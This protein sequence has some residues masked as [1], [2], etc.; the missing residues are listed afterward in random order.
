MID[1][2]FVIR[3]SS[4]SL[5]VLYLFLKNEKVD[6]GET[7]KRGVVRRGFRKSVW[8][9]DVTGLTP[10]EGYLKKLSRLGRGRNDFFAPTTRT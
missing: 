7:D 1:Q 9:R 2:V 4:R 10:Q 5:E 6:D 8:S 3:S